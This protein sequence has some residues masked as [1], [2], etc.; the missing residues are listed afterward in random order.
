MEDNLLETEFNFLANDDDPL[1]DGEEIKVQENTY[2]Q[3]PL[4]KDSKERMAPAA[5]NG[6]EKRM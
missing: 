6:R 2:K 4:Q 3:R 5:N 1:M